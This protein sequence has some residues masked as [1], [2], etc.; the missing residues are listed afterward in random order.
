MGGDLGTVF[1]MH[2]ES[3]FG[4]LP[5][6]LILILT[7][8]VASLWHAASSAIKGKHRPKLRHSQQQHAHWMVAPPAASEW[9]PSMES[10]TTSWVGIL[11]A[12]L[13][14]ATLGLWIAPSCRRGSIGRKVVE[15][16]DYLRR[17]ALGNRLI[18]ALRKCMHGGS[19]SSPATH[20]A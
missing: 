9:L 12:I 7:R 15:R 10:R 20:T 2:G 16:C 13:V 18:F 8:S 17:R 11:V 19:S 14:I 3:A 1:L 6:A 5:A 4:G